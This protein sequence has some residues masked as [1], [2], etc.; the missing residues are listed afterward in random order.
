MTDNNV[1]GMRT[2]KTNLDPNLAERLNAQAEDERVR[3]ELERKLQANK[4]AKAGDEEAK[5]AKGKIIGYEVEHWS[6]N[7]GLINSREEWLE[8]WSRLGSG[9]TTKWMSAGDLYGA[10]KQM[11]D[12]QIFQDMT[13]IDADLRSGMIFNTRVIYNFGG[14][15]P[16]E[17]IVIHDSIVVKN[18]SNTGFE[19]PVYTNDRIESVIASLAGS[20]FIQA[21]FDTKDDPGTIIRYLNA[22]TGINADKMLVSTPFIGAR[23]IMFTKSAVL[24]LCTQD[25]SKYLI[26]GANNIFTTVPVQKG[27][28]R[29][30]RI[31]REGEA[32]KD[33]EPI[34]FTT[35]EHVDEWRPRK[36]RND[37]DL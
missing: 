9:N 11:I 17:G 5:P 10:L 16:L 3:A 29:G 12:T 18:G 21:Y 19:I 2:R 20:K 1:L 35:T 26:I 15:N 34:S 36:R 23:E 33:Y 32:K 22:A 37:D 4:A 28:S 24:Y 13:G 25:D 31:I 14:T 8:Y 27:R 7:G 30:V 6:A